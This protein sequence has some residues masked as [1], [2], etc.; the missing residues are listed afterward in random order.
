MNENRLRLRRV[1]SVGSYAEILITPRISAIIAP[2]DTN[3]SPSIVSP[4]INRAIGAM[5]TMNASLCFSA[6]WNTSRYI[7]TNSNPPVVSNNP[8]I[9]NPINV[10]MSALRFKDSSFNPFLSS[11]IEIPRGP[12]SNIKSKKII[13][14]YN[15]PK[16][17]LASF[18]LYAIGAVTAIIV[19]VAIILPDDEACSSLITSAIIIPIGTIINSVHKVFFA[20]SS[21]P[22][23]V[24]ATVNRTIGPI[25]LIRPRG[26][27]E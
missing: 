3:L 13:E 7:G 9:S 23:E 25:R 4:N 5:H 15:T 17:L 24:S 8:R 20:K 21:N 14:L 16:S 1:T 26:P 6:L 27:Q 2:S 22:T 19:N 12:A 11:I 10:V 18:R